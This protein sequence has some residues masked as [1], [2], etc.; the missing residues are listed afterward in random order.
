LT[1]FY[2]PLEQEALLHIAGPDAL[3]F[4]QGQTTCDT[5]AVSEIHSV[6][7][8]Y[9]TPQGR[10]VCDFLLSQLGQDHFALRMRR[11]I[12]S[13]S[14]QV[15]GKY[16]IFSKAELNA[17]NQE[18]QCLGIWGPGAENVI[19]ELV[20]LPAGESYAVARGPG[21]A[22]ARL[23]GAENA[24]EC[25]VHTSATSTTLDTLQRSAQPDTEAH[26][27]LLQINAGV[28]RITSNTV[29]EFVP[30]IINYDLTG[31][32]NFKKGCYTGQ[33]VVARLHYRGTPKRRTFLARLEAEE[34]PEAGTA[35]YTA[36]TEQSIGNIVNACSTDGHVTALVA[37][38]LES[39]VG[40]L[41]LGSPDGS[42][43]SV[44]PP[45]YSL[46]FTK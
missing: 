32:V 41:Y 44:E 38:T 13:N 4:L 7:G 43:L 21:I 2:C 24:F 27:Q 22:V 5:E 3:K 16:I 33:E 39:A 8:A 12:V 36:E 18:W 23:P 34:V 11:D 19:A 42:P 1:A 30:Q 6:A 15:L 20:D 37:V 28:A 26:W 25:Y 31:H 46:E 29:E 40:A 45:P 35:L 17:E 9:C 10:V 14:A